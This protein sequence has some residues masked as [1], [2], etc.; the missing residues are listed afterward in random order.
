VPAEAPFP[1]EW[2]SA[3]LNL[4][5]HV[6]ELLEYPDRRPRCGFD[7]GCEALRVAEAVVVSAHEGG[8]RIEL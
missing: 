7:D 6:V 2:Q 3:Y 8:R 1:N 5:D 4:A